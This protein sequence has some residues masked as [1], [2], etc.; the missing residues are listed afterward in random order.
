[1]SG[2][3]N[4][5][6]PYHPDR[7]HTH[8]LIS[9]PALLAFLSL[10][11]HIY[12]CLHSTPSLLLN[13]LTNTAAS[14]TS[15]TPLPAMF[16]CNTAVPH[17]FQICSSPCFAIHRYFTLLH[18]CSI[19]CFMLTYTQGSP[20]LSMYSSPSCFV[21]YHV[22]TPYI[23]PSASFQCSYRYRQA[24]RPPCMFSCAL[25]LHIDT[26]FQ[27]EHTLFMMDISPTFRYLHISSRK[28]PGNRAP[29]YFSHI[30]AWQMGP[31]HLLFFPFVEPSSFD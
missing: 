24:S 25:L 19:L 31:F 17:S 28:L 8:T 11:A 5:K 26:R 4:E 20:L 6:S 14:N 7:D 3:L 16:T 15:L 18:S 1:V 27:Y 12:R 23:E 30:D 22:C 10:H 13:M 2:E 21:Q 29:Q 9:P